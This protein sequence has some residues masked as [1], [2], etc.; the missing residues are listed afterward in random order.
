MYLWEGKQDTLIDKLRETLSNNDG[1]ALL[2][3]VYSKLVPHHAAQILQ[4]LS[5]LGAVRHR[6]KETMSQL[7]SRMN[8]LFKR[9]K[10]LGYETVDQLFVAYTQL[11]VF[12]GHY[13]GHDA[14]KQERIQVDHHQQDL[15]RYA[16]P[17]EFTDAMDEAF[18]NNQL[19]KPGSN[20]MKSYNA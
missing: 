7:H 19:L 20:E 6:N 4:L 1:V 11:A 17:R 3:E 9:I 2:H 16:D 18:L 8:Q 13:K 14:V 12:E 15:K 10:N 5:E